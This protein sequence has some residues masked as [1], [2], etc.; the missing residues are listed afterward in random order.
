VT[1][2]LNEGT[3]TPRVL[4]R[5]APGLLEQRLSTQ[6]ALPTARDMG[7]EIAQAALNTSL[8]SGATLVIGAPLESMLTS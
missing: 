4:E 5:S 3:I 2:D 6:G 1:G 7:R 8:V